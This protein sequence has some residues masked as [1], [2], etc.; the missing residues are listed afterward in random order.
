MNKPAAPEGVEPAPPPV[1]NSRRP[2]FL[3]PAPKG[4]QQISPGQR[5]GNPRQRPGWN[6]GVVNL[7]WVRFFVLMAAIAGAPHSAARDSDHK[8]QR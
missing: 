8:K 6:L 4:P 2:S 1:V 5:P 3:F 7:V